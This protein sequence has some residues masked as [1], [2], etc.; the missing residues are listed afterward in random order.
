MRHQRSY[1]LHSAHPSSSNQSRRSLG[2]Q[3][4]RIRY[5]PALDG[6][7]IASHIVQPKGVTA[8]ILPQS[9]QGCIIPCYDLQLPQS[10]ASAF[11]CIQE[12]SLRTYTVLMRRGV[13]ASFRATRSASVSSVGSALVVVALHLAVA[14]AGASSGVVVGLACLY[15]QFCYSHP[16]PHL[17]MTS[18]M[19]HWQR[20]QTPSLSM[21]TRQPL[22]TWPGLLHIAQAGPP[23]P[24]RRACAEAG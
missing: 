13:L 24:S 21:N 5:P 14:A 2:S 23:A 20:L 10:W 9:A 16:F 17:C 7:D 18:C 11:G 22:A 8:P 12:P 4:N 15:L 3:L 1:R 19:N 6:V